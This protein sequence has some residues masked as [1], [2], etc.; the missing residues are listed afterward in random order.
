MDNKIKLNLLI[1]IKNQLL[2]EAFL[3]YLSNSQSLKN[4]FEFQID[5]KPQNERIYEI[6]IFDKST[7]RESKPEESKTEDYFSS[8]KLLLDDGSLEEEIVFLF[9]YYRLSGVLSSDISLSL[10]GKCLEVVLRGEIWVSNHLVK[11][12]CENYDSFFTKKGLE[13]L[14]F[15]EREVVKLICEGLSNKE[16]ALRLFISEQTVKTHLNHIFKKTGA[17]NRNQLI[18]MY[19]YAIGKER[20]QVS[21]ADQI[22]TLRPIKKLLKLKRS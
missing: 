4:K 6:V 9:L 15:K 5:L 11:K 7:L 10:F 13:N 14:T 17:K 8:K 12:I 22:Q 19:F 21:S 2:A 3:F 1:K 20:V 16:I 18:K